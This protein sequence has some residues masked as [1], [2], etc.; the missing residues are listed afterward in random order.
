MKD[1]TNGN[2]SFSNWFKI[3]WKN[4]YIQLFVVFFSV[5]VIQVINIKKCIEILLEVKEDTLFAFLFTSFYMLI[6]LLVVVTIIHKGFIQFWNDL[7]NGRS[8]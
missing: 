3:M 1:Y 6:P 8:R 7:K 4:S 5:L 2:H